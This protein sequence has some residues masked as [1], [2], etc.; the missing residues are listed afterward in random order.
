MNDE[1]KLISVGEFIIPSGDY[2]ITTTTSLKSYIFSITTDRENI[3]IEGK[4]IPK[5]E[6]KLIMNSDIYDAE[7]ELA[8]GDNSLRESLMKGEPIRKSYF[9]GVVLPSNGKYYFSNLNKPFE[10]SN[11]SY[12]F[13]LILDLNKCPYEIIK[14]IV[15][16]GFANDDFYSFEKD[17]INISELGVH[18]L[19][20]T[21]SVVS[22]EKHQVNNST[23][24]WQG[25]EIVNRSRHL[26]IKKTNYI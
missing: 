13:L 3:E 20:D 9:Y 11:I 17:S 15:K 18:V 14:P 19:L 24:I 21:P 2:L 5:N 22:T 26:R 4:L 7:Y 25:I 8:F 1:E 10:Y 6:T 23:Y 12:G 16:Y